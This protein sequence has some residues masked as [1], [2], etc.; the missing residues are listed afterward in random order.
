[1][2]ECELSLLQSWYSMLAKLVKTHGIS[3][4]STDHLK[5]KKKNVVLLAEGGEDW[6]YLLLSWAILTYRMGTVIACLGMF[7]F[8][9]S[10]SW[11]LYVHMY[12]VFAI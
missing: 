8:L 1:M 9:S 11:L 6:R 2:Y 12:I 4:D 5:I 3:L 7:L 10:L